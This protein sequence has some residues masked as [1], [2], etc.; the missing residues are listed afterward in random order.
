MQLDPLVVPGGLSLSSDIQDDWGYTAGYPPAIVFSIPPMPLTEVAVRNARADDKPRKLFDAHGLF[1]FVTPKGGK[2]WRL[3]YRFGGK[4]K[5]LSLGPYP[6]IGLRE[7]RDARDTARR[8][9]IAGENPGLA[10]A[11]ARQATFAALNNTLKQIS[12]EYQAKLTREGRAPATLEKLEWYLTFVLPAL[13]ELDV[14]S[15]T[16][17]QVLDVLRTIES[18]GRYE[19]ARKTRSTVGAIFRYAIATARA[20]NDPTSALR[21]ALT[22]PT[23]KPRAAILD[24]AA[25]GGLL[26]A[27]W[28]YDGSPEVVAGLKLLALLYPRPGELRHAD[29]SEFD[30][31]GAIWTVPA[32]RMKMRR[33]HRVPLSREAIE[34][35]SDLE[36][37]RTHATALAFP[38]LRSASR[39]LSE[40]TFNA[41]LRRMGFTTDQATAHGFRA[42]F[43]TMANESRLW[44][45]DAIERAL[46]HVEEKSARRAYA[47]G[48]H[49]D[50]R[51]RMAA[52]W[53]ERCDQ[54]RLG[55]EAI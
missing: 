7:A 32:S 54:L 13:G 28:A 38:S 6:L 53:S 14:R 37:K 19:T 3:K 48:E 41:A 10:K 17:A 23:V 25:F 50:E 36:K 4:E 47:R 34:I 45:A 27:V 21:G 24:P 33:P 26:R 22:R 55:V 1:L 18:R 11:N 15:I 29:W 42:S 43:S 9:V 49:W 39:C 46:A 2:L 40:N 5:L 16:A 52:W 35:L 31:G 44:S 20:E 30:L 12:E 8:M 51:M